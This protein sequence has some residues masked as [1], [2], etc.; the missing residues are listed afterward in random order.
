ME[1]SQQGMGQHGA[2]QGKL[3]RKDSGKSNPV[4]TNQ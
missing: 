3:G 1:S 4:N 2:L